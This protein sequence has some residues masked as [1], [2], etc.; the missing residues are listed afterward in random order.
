[1]SEADKK[2]KEDEGWIDSIDFWSDDEAEAEE[3]AEEETG[4]ED[5]DIRKKGRRAKKEDEDEELDVDSARALNKGG[6]NENE[7]P[8]YKFDLD[9]L[10]SDECDK[11]PEAKSYLIKLNESDSETYV[12]IENPDGTKNNSPTADSILNILYDYLK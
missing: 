8:A 1:M 12:T 6:A 5:G 9:C 2:A 7:G 3:M 4:A 10:F 11:E